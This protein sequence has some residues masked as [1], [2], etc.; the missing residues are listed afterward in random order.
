MIRVNTRTYKMKMMMIMKEWKRERERERKKS[1]CCVDVEL[2]QTNNNTITRVDLYIQS[3]LVTNEYI[4]IYICTMYIVHKQ[5][6]YL[7][8]T[9]T[10]WCV[11]YIQSMY[12]YIYWIYICLFIHSFIHSFTGCWS[13]QFNLHKK[14]STYKLTSNSRNSNSTSSTVWRQC[15]LWWSKVLWYIINRFKCAITIVLEL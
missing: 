13:T 6:P 14:Q 12:I 3:W 15:W 4:Y 10:N 1:D 11:W 8:F 5:T 7:L 2:K 9:L